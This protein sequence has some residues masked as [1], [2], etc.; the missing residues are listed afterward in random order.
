MSTV[1]VGPREFAEKTVEKIR[2]GARTV[3]LGQAVALAGM[4]A[5]AIVV[6]GFHPYAD[7]AGIYASGVL[8][9]LH[10]HMFGPSTPFIAAYTHLSLF[11]QF[12]AEA[13]RL[14]H[15][16]L[17]AVLLGFQFFGIWLLLYACREI[18]RKCGFTEAGA[19]GAAL[20]M[21]ICLT[22]PVA[23][24]SLVM[25]DP[26]V[27]SRTLSMPFTMMAISAA[28]D[29][30]AAKTG[31][32]L[33]LTAVIH[34]LMAI[35]AAGFLL[36][37]WMALEARWRWLAALTA[38]PLALAAAIAFSQR[39][40]VESHA[41]R[42]AAL[43]R[44]FFYLSQWHWYELF[45]L[46]GPLLFLAW[47]CWWKPGQWHRPDRALCAACYAIAVSCVAVAL[48][49][50]HPG[51]HSHLIARL[52]TLRTYSI[53]YVVLFLGLGAAIEQQLVRREMW[54]RV[55]IFGLLAT[56]MASIQFV[57]YAS[58]RHLELPW[59]Q[60]QNQWEQAFLWVRANTPPNALFA[61]DADYINSPGEDTQVFRAI[62]QRAS[63]ADQS[64][65]G[66][67]AAVF[68][69]LAPVWLTESTA[70]AG[71]SASSDA[72]RVQRLAPFGVTWVIL[73]QTART[74][75]DC[76]YQNAAVKVCR[77]P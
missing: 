18:A 27:T 60:P 70:D 65:D 43:S 76:P 53:I 52:Q 35:Y 8:L 39:H 67:T 49:F 71:L 51:S 36:M 34:P 25:M 23:G 21:A 46:V 16:R 9:A 26:Y 42:L 38:T 3:A 40:V 74:A 62:A 5:L 73:R 55:L 32:W 22:V 17:S 66:G 11:S 45:G 48:C 64:K 50:S 10:P 47:Y 77:L 58:T 56:G 4:A 33:A 54:R 59:T 75:F 12:V 31:V 63:L 15:L 14:T 44:E 7:D 30:K 57:Q 69:A 20:M 29:R 41:Y 28:L 72:Q 24:T 2:S 19:W 1:V 68:P 61:L 37:L 6:Q 13:V